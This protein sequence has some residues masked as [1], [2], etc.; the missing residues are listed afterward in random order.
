MIDA[1]DKSACE[2]GRSV[3]VLPGGVRSPSP[4]D[5]QPGSGRADSVLSVGQGLTAFLN[6]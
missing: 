3:W 1:F 5:K 6:K 2:R 4:N